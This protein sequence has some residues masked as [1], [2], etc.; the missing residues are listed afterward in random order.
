MFHVPRADGGPPPR[1]L[2][3][4][5][6]QATCGE[7][8]GEEPRLLVRPA[9]HVRERQTGARLL[10]AVDVDLLPRS[11]PIRD[12]EPLGPG[13]SDVAETQRKHRPG[14][15]GNAAVTLALV[16]ARYPRGQDGRASQRGR[17][18]RSVRRGEPSVAELRP[19]ADDPGPDRADDRLVTGRRGPGQRGRNADALLLPAEAGSHR[20]RRRQELTLPHDTHAVREWERQRP[21]GK[22]DVCDAKALVDTRA[23][24][25]D[26]AVKR[27][28]DDGQ[29]AEPLRERVSLLGVGNSDLQRR[30]RQLHHVRRPGGR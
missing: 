21:A 15:M 4:E 29:T 27:A 8:R 7:R 10:P 12:L 30:I 3:D 13:N 22:L 16:R 25:R 6:Q 11:D 20:D 26:L 28:A 24:R 18:I 14:V 2:S 17:R 1:L 23:H 5:A 19:G 9:A